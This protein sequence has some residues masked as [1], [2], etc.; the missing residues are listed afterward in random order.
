MTDDV[1]STSGI[2]CDKAG[3]EGLRIPADNRGM[4]VLVCHLDVE[5]CVPDSTDLDA[6]DEAMAKRCGQRGCEHGEL[7][8][9]EVHDV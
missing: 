7:Q 5:A 3:V 2:W 1:R 4:R 9:G 8:S 6:G